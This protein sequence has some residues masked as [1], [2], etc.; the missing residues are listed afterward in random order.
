VETGI[1][2]KGGH[3]QCAVS[4]SECSRGARPEVESFRVGERRQS[5]ELPNGFKSGLDV[6]FDRCRNGVHD[7]HQVD[8]AGRP[9]LRGAVQIQDLLLSPWRL[10]REHRDVSRI[11]D[12]RGDRLLEVSIHQKRM[13]NAGA[14]GRIQTAGAVECRDRRIEQPHVPARVNQA[15]I[16]LRVA[17]AL[18]YAFQKT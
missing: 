5:A 4:V 14:D 17:R 11:V 9:L 16:Q 8:V 10:Q 6:P 3:L 18:A 15:R 12:V 2:G 1:D 7:K 13:G